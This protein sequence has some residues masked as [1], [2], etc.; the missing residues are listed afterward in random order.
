MS[1]QNDREIEVGQVRIALF[2]DKYEYSYVILC[3]T[4]KGQYK[5][6]KVK[7]LEHHD[8]AEVGRVNTWFGCSCVKDVVMM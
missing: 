7:I 2:G 6:V 1:L 3:I 8:Q 4:D 5:S